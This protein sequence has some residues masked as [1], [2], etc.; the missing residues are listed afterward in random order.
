[1]NTFAC[2]SD[3]AAI[4]NGHIVNGFMFEHGNVRAFKRTKRKN[5]LYAGKRRAAPL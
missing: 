2:R 1:M 4:K 3:A 5:V